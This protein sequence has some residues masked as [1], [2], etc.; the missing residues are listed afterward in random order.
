[1]TLPWL[2]ARGFLILYKY[3]TKNPLTQVLSRT[4]AKGMCNRGFLVGVV[5]SPDRG[6]GWSAY[7]PSSLVNFSLVEHSLERSL[8]F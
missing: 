5:T 3:G 6:A 2:E 7:L 8:G 4:N 1:M